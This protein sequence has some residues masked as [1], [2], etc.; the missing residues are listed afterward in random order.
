MKLALRY[1]RLWPGGHTISPIYTPALPG[2]ADPKRIV[3]ID[4]RNQSRGSR[5]FPAPATSGVQR[6]YIEAR[7]VFI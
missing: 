1:Q 7:A 5:A 2:L 3:G 6:A 4:T